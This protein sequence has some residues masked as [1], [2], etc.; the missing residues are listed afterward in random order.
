MSPPNIHAATSH[1]TPAMKMILARAF[2]RANEDLIVDRLMCISPEAGPNSR[3]AKFVS[4]LLDRNDPLMA[5]V[6]ERY[7]PCRLAVSRLP[8]R[9][10]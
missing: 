8:R 7:S 6:N 1:S 3:I 5:A 10:G 9:V 4:E 2:P